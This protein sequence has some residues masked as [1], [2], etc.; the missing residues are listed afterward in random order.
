[1]SGGPSP[2]GDTTT[3]RS[4]ASFTVSGLRAFRVDHQHRPCQRGPKLGQ[5]LLPGTG[6]HRASNAARCSPASKYLVS[7]IA[8]TFSTSSC[9]ASHAANVPGRPATSRSAITNRLVA[10]V[11]DKRSASPIWS[12]ANSLHRD[13]RPTSL[14]E[15]N[16]RAA[17]ELREQLGFGY[18]QWLFLRDIFEH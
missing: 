18:K 16:V 10:G 2:S 8:R 4:L 11:R 6:Q 13:G 15:R 1:M 7:V 12:E 17:G 5:G 9:P 14:A 3:R